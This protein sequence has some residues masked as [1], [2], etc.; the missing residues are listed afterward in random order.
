MPTAVPQPRTRQGKGNLFMHEGIS[1]TKRSQQHLM[2]THASINHQRKKQTNNQTNKITTMKAAWCSNPRRMHDRAAQRPAATA[3][4]PRQSK[5]APNVAVS[6]IRRW[7]P[8]T[9]TNNIEHYKKINQT[10]Y[11]NPK[12]QFQ[13][14]TLIKE[15]FLKADLFI[16]IKTHMHVTIL[17]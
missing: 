5:C 12:H 17:N 6:Q 4:H 10:R 14:L 1:P 2:I 13:H 16:P 7:K 11:T 9:T 15:N 3:T 8:R